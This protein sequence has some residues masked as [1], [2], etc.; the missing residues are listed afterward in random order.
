ME[1]TF[2]EKFALAMHLFLTAILVGCSIGIATS[3]ADYDPGCVRQY[4]LYGLRGT[5]RTI[6]DGP[7]NPDGGWMRLRNFHDDSRYIPLSCYRYS[8]SGGYWLREFDK[9][10]VYYV[11][12]SNV[13]PDEPGHI[14]QG[15]MA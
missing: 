9:E 14:A 13:L 6:C 4:W 2:K 5:I 12:P 3:R 11:L 10:D 7:I 1:L 15:T 8:C